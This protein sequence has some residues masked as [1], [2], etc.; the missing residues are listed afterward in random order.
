LYLLEE[1]AN[2]PLT[3]FKMNESKEK[4]R[5]VSGKGSRQKGF[6][7]VKLEYFKALPSAMTKQLQSPEPVTGQ[8]HLSPIPVSDIKDEL[9]PHLPV[10]NAPLMEFSRTGILR[11]LVHEANNLPKIT[12][13]YFT[14][15]I[16]YDDTV[17]FTSSIVQRSDA[18]IWQ[19]SKYFLFLMTCS[20]R[21]LS[22]ECR[23]RLFEYSSMAIH[24]QRSPRPR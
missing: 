3:N 16:S 19:Q 13:C 11:V 22:Q 9:P 18:P 1:S 5:A 24:W 2:F 10:Q 23:R 20:C 17:Q 7:H 15:K 8:S 14:M 12:D 4:E 6:L 21:C